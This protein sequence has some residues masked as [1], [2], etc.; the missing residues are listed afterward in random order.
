MGRSDTGDTRG[1]TKEGVERAEPAARTTR[2]RHRCQGPRPCRRTLQASSPHSRLLAR[3]APCLAEGGWGQPRT[4]L[5]FLARI[6][7]LHVPR[8]Q[9][10]TCQSP[11]ARFKHRKS[12][13][14][15][16]G[17]NMPVK[18]AARAA[19]GEAS[20]RR[21]GLGGKGIR[22]PL[23]W[24]HPWRQGYS[25]QG[26]S[27]LF[28]IFIITPSWVFAQSSRTWGRPLSVE[29]GREATRATGR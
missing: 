3:S 17:I 21:K 2:F 16:R 12:N 19:A 20:N 6:Q 27:T 1:P 8:D 5:G 26:Y 7:R 25:R 9:Q 15:S 23:S 11:I 22:L 24:R 14:R 13:S 18:A 29:K 28:I 4:N 10:S